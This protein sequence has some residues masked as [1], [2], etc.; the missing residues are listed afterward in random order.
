MSPPPLAWGAQKKGSP[1]KPNEPRTSHGLRDPQGISQTPAKHQPNTER[2][3]RPHPGLTWVTVASRRPRLRPRRRGLRVE[4]EERERGAQ[5]GGREA[6]HNAGPE[7][8]SEEDVPRVPKATG[9]TALNTRSTGQRR[10][11]ASHPKCSTFTPRPPLTFTP[12]ATRRRALRRDCG[13]TA[14]L[15]RSPPTRAGVW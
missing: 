6:S 10:T 4:V 7:E 11:A 14:A 2:L 8:G 5:G 13:W 1:L 12:S 9:G 3:A 15:L